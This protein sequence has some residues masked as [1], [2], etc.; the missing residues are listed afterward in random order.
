[1]RSR[2]LASAQCMLYLNGAPWG[3][4]TAFRWDS[5]TPSKSISGLDSDNPFELAPT[6][7][8]IT[9]SVQVVRVSNDGGLEGYGLI[10]AFEEIP[11]GKYFSLALVDRATDTQIF[12]A[13]NC[14]CSGQ[15]WD[16]PTKGLVTGSFSFEALSW[17]NESA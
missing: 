3:I 9:G 4:V 14:R 5:A 17:S 2:V 13:D 8:R 16:V 15:S 6:T 10:P 11:R 1:M 12:R 7:T